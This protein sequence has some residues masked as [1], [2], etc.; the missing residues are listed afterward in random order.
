MVNRY[1]GSSSDAS[2]NTH[3]AIKRSIDETTS[4]NPSSTGVLGL[5]RTSSII[6]PEQ[7]LASSHSLSS[8]E[9]KTTTT[10]RLNAEFSSPAPFTGLSLHELRSRRE[11]LNEIALTPQWRDHVPAAIAALRRLL[12]PNPPPAYQ[13]LVNAC[14][15]FAAFTKSESFG[16]STA[17]MNIRKA[18]QTLIQDAESL[19]AS[20]SI[21]ESTSTPPSKRQRVDHAARTTLADTV[22]QPKSDNTTSQL[23]SCLNRL[24]E[25]P[26][27]AKDWSERAEPI[28]TRLLKVIE[29][30][31]QLRA[32]HPFLHTLCLVFDTSNNKVVGDELVKE[33]HKV[34]RA[35][36]QTIAA[37][38]KTDDAAKAMA[39]DLVFENATQT[40]IYD[41]LCQDPTMP[42]AE[43][44]K[45]LPH[46]STGAIT[47]AA[48]FVRAHIAFHLPANKFLQILERVARSSTATSF[49][50]NLARYEGI[51]VSPDLFEDM[52]S[53]LSTYQDR[54]GGRTPVDAAGIA[55][56]KNLLKPGEPAA[57]VWQAT[58][59]GPTGCISRQQALRDWTMQ[60]FNPANQTST[61]Q[62]DPHSTLSG[63][64]RR[65]SPI[66]AQIPIERPSKS[67]T[68]RGMPRRQTQEAT[69]QV[70]SEVMAIDT[71]DTAPLTIKEAVRQKPYEST[72]KLR[73]RLFTHVR[74][75][76]VQTEAIST[77]EELAFSLPD[78]QSILAAITFAAGAKNATGFQISLSNVGLAMNQRAFLDWKIALDIYKQTHDNKI[79]STEADL[80][81]FVTCIQPSET[82]VIVYFATAG[83][84][85]YCK[86]L[87][88]A[89]ADWREREPTKF[90]PFTN[91]P[92]PRHP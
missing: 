49:V 23:E 51:A 58:T 85:D 69:S 11:N 72:N 1:I 13:S 68:E 73:A 3:T 28:T 35:S 61:P 52:E 70:T 25:I 29:D 90:E 62:T 44:L 16:D 15:E 57:A 26:N 46:L 77:R 21:V 75:A 7:F 64:G 12:P 88:D 43:I 22:P 60:R 2:T 6:D 78:V 66:A 9:E 89:I 81:E 33:L 54:H 39:A 56:F 40:A 45:K 31:E 8:T 50:N 92:L 65:P 36:Q 42:N 20:G 30:D 32:Q 63:D 27:D 34:V 41:V 86:P 47:P 79:P 59:S 82:A 37:P 55:A 18:L 84:G 38:T 87:A 80:A 48:A 10:V 4:R 5:H 19:Q 74:Y 83:H 71:P 24:D 14:D 67:T 76:K 53:A 17:L 91:L